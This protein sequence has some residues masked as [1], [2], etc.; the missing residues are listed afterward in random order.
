[1]SDRKFLDSAPEGF[2]P[3]LDLAWIECDVEEFHS[4]PTFSV[5]A[6]TNDLAPR[7][8]CFILCQKW[9]GAFRDC[10]VRIPVA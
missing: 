8:P 10:W 9:S 7:L 6:P 1:M 4:I 3:T 2:S 5:H